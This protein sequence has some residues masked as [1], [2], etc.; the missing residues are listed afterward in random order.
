MGQAVFR[1]ALTELD[2]NERLYNGPG[3]ISDSIDWIRLK[4][5]TL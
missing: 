1:I 3:C 4:W 5:K 2:L